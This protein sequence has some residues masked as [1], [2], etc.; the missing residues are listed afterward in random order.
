MYETDTQYL[1]IFVHQLISEEPGMLQKRENQLQF[2]TITKR[3]IRILTAFGQSK[4][5]HLLEMKTCQEFG[6][7]MERT[8]KAYSAYV[9]N[10]SL[11]NLIAVR[12]VSDH[13]RHI[14]L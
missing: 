1:L 13:F 2:I 11:H 7:E 9:Q 4:Q 3:C 8:I 14:V 5:M 6:K 12:H 10:E